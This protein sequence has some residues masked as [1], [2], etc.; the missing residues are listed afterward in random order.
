M[1]KNTGTSELINYFTLGANGDVGIAGSL[2]INTIANATTDTDTFLVSDTWIIKYRTGAQL[3]LDIGAQGLLT[4]PVTGTGTTNYLPK[5]TGASTIGN[6]VIQE[7]S[8]NIGIGVGPSFP[9]DLLTG[10]SGT[11][12]TIA[13]FFNNDFTAGNRS[14]LRVRQQINAGASSSSYFGTGQDTHLYIIAN[15][16]ARGGDIIINASTGNVGIGIQPVNSFKLDVSGTARFSSSIEATAAYITNAAF[17]EGV[18]YFDIDTFGGK[19]LRLNN[20]GNQLIM[21][22]NGIVS[23]GSV[24]NNGSGAVLQV[25]GAATFSSSVT[26]ASG[27]N[28]IGQQKAFSW[29]RTAGTASDIYS[30]NADSVSAYLQNDTT[31]NILTYWTEGGNVLIGTTTDNGA[32]L[33]VTDA[34]T[35]T[36]SVGAAAAGAGAVLGVFGSA[37]LTF[38]T[39]GLSNERMRITSGGKVGIQN[40]D[41]QGK[42]EVGK[43]EANNTYGGHFFS[44]FQIPIN[45]WTTVFTAPNNN[46]NAITEFTWTSSGDY[47]RSGAA[48]MRWAYNGGSASLGVVYTLFNDSQN[49]TATF[50][51]SGGA[52]Q[53][54]ITGGAVDYYVQVRIQ[55]SKA[56]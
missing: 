29:Q 31:G 49:S 2:D 5:F 41:P 28:A 11:F 32:K 45:T 36:F 50:R 53:I 55:G 51:N 54:N 6:S 22:T 12:N 37:A 17:T 7:A 25:T 3:L 56:A 42:F 26:A 24:G 16:S 48:Y 35:Y 30:L 47:N 34:S 33:T 39:N 4:N 18:T 43:V 8:S 14:Y 1:S 46:W 44:T 38:A 10:S 52:I 27:I 13:Q 9:L 15:D 23:I 19:K 40:S 20:A 21:G